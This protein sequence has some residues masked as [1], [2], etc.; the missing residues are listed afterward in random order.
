MPWEEDHAAWR[1]A[2][3][4]CRECERIERSLDRTVPES[5]WRR[6][7]ADL[8]SS[9]R[10]DRFQPPVLLGS[11]FDPD[12]SAGLRDP[13]PDS[14]HDSGDDR[15]VK[16]QIPSAYAHMRKERSLLELKR[17]AES[18]E[19]KLEGTLR[20]GPTLSRPAWEQECARLE[21]EV[22]RAWTEYA[23]KLHAAEPVQ[24]S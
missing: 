3:N 9:N 4:V 23:D 13:E 21:A 22:T 7:L 17:E 10:W 8:A 16:Q 6:W 14:P 11:A 18:L 15:G 12:G 5:P 1:A 19:V 24:T 20:R 2:G